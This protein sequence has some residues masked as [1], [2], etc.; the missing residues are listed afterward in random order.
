MLPYPLI[1]TTLLSGCMP[2]FIVYFILFFV[3]AC[4][5]WKFLGQGFDLCHSSDLSCYSDNTRSSWWNSFYFFKGTHF[6]FYIPHIN[7]IAWDMSFSI[8]NLTITKLHLL[9]YFIYPS[10]LK[11]HPC[12]WKW[13]NA[14]LFLFTYFLCCCLFRAALAAHGGSQARGR[15][16]TLAAGLHHSHSNTRSEPCL[17]P[18]A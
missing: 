12:C 5:I 18:T 11:I 6:I 13:Q 4:S 8:C 1:T 14:I 10:T 3:C 2:F 16:G 7:E 17:W 9:I 15:I